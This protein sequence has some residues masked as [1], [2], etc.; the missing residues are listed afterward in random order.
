MK[1]RIACALFAICLGAAN[2]QQLLMNNDSVIK[3][4]EARMSDGIIVSTRR[5]PP[6]A[7]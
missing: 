6:L 7:E 1:I 5:A 3:M 4:V 2:A